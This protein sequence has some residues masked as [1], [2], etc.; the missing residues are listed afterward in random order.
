MVQRPINDHLNPMLN[1]STPPP[2]TN[3]F[4]TTNTYPY[5]IA[6]SSGPITLDPEAM[7]DIA[8]PQTDQLGNV[9]YPGMENIEQPMFDL[10]D[11]Q[12]FF[13]WENSENGPPPTGVDGLGPLGWNNLS[14]MQ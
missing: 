11:L 3:E 13:E 14:S 5:S 7:Q 9:Y 1:V 8:P 12:N 4:A 6:T 10:N 2:T